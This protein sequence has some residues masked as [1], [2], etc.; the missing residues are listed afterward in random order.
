MRTMFNLFCLLLIGAILLS[1]CNMPG[2]ATVEETATASP[3]PAT[4]TPEPS[5]TP[6]EAPPTET[7]TET[8]TETP[9]STPTDTATPLPP[10][11]E[12]NRESNCRVGPATCMTWL[13]PIRQGKC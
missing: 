7:P 13:Q 11:A 9:L 3:L 1:A 4:D 5:A 6:T 8:A 2:S 10:M 12:V